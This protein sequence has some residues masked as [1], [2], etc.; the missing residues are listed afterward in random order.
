MSHIQALAAD[1]LATVESGQTLTDALAGV[2]QRHPG[3]A[4]SDRGALLDISYGV[5][6]F[7]GELIHVLR[8]LVPRALPE[9]A[10][11]RVLLVALFQLIHTRAAEYAVVNEAVKLASGIA[12]GRFK[13][14]VNGVLRNALRRKDAL[15]AGAQARDESRY[16]H[17]LWWIKAMRRAYPSQW[18]DVLLAGN[19]HPPMTLRVNRRR[20]SVEASLARLAAAGIGA[21]ASSEDAITLD[22]PRNV[23]DLPGFAE[24]E[25]SVQDLG[26]QRAVPLLDLADGMRVLDACAAP[27]GKTCHMLERFDVSVTALD[28]DPAR[29]GRV[30]ENLD[31][32]GLSAELA[33]ADAGKFKDRW[34][35]EPF[36][37]ILADVPCSASGVVRRHPD[38]KWLRRPGDFEELARQQAVIMDGLWQV[39]ATG[40]KMLYATCSIFPQ[41]NG[42]QLDAFLGRHPEAVCT[43]QEQLLPTEAHD[44]F[45]YAL[46][47]KR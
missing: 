26:A 2:L 22:V 37:R 16:N 25:L 24:G 28:A 29:L 38:I 7:K 39:L 40:G 13:G 12:A 30:R 46:L 33:A 41:E 1:I 35:G 34:S 4:A 23:R 44:G 19:G 43:Y 5:Q 18:Q 42:V 21:V 15:I 32:L 6:R 27:G 20:S 45:Y 47:E 8:D 31:R 10:L 3:L 14:L 36:D 17:P 9:P 11:E